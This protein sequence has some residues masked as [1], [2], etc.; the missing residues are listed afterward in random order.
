MTTSDEQSAPDQPVLAGSP[1]LPPQAAPSA[2]PYG[3]AP[4]PPQAYGAPSTTP[5]T[6]MNI[7]SFVTALLVIPIVP[8]I[9][10]H[11]GV[12]ASNKGKAELKGLGIAGLVI[13]YLELVFGI[14]LVAIVVGALIAT[15]DT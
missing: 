12:S 1:V 8:I 11:M 3:A 14:I 7:T 2:T 4:L 6:W 13:G 10:G 9:F 15:T 5:N